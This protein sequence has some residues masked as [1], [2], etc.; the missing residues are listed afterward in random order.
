[1]KCAQTRHKTAYY[2]L[3]MGEQNRCQELFY[4][5]DVGGSLVTGQQRYG[6]ERWSL[7]LDTQVDAASRP[8]CVDSTCIDDCAENFTSI[9]G[10]IVFSATIN[11]RF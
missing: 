5:T 11:G 3:Q 7:G 2:R 9:S 10:G 6:F 1:M 4:E 8:A